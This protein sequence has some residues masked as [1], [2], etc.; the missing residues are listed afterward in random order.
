MVNVDG[1]S[2]LADSQ[3][4]L[5]WSENWPMPFE[6]WTRLS[7]RKHI[8]DG[9]AHLRHLTIATEPSM[10]SGK[11]DLCEITLTT[12]YYC[13]YYYT[14]YI[15]DAWQKNRTRIN[16][17]KL[18]LVSEWWIRTARAGRI[19]WTISTCGG[20]SLLRHRF[21]MTHVTFRRNDSGIV[22]LTNEMSG[23]TMPSDTT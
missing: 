7:W 5:A 1:S 12:C 18:T 10:C 16:H 6:T 14:Q 3:P 4:Q 2:L 19:S 20:G 11:A 8:L 21:T 13:Y 22:G 23:F 15:A 17:S 9:G